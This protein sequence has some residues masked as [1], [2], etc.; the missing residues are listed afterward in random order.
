MQKALCAMTLCA[1][2]AWIAGGIVQ[3]SAAGPAGAPGSKEDQ[4]LQVEQQRERA[5]EASDIPTLDKI[6]ADD[7]IYCHTGGRI[8]TKPSMLDTLKKFPG[9]Y[10]KITL[11]DT[12]VR[13]DG[14][15]AVI[16]GSIDFTTTGGGRGVSTQHALTTIVYEKRD[17]RWQMIS[18]QSTLKP[19]P[20]ADGA[21]APA[22]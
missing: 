2:A 16:N 18:E 4:V 12:K 8:D 22:R 10:Q 9:R 5:Q 3:T 7:L 1:G 14:N 19:E 17:G 11:S 15:M 21:P 20:G 13:V 6:L